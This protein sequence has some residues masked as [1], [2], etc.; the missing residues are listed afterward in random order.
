MSDVCFSVRPD[1]D[2]DDL[3]AEGWMCVFVTAGLCVGVYLCVCIAGKK[4][5]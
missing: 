2:S 1:S 3:T 4:D 5:M